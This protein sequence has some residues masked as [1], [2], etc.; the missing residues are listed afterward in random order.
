MPNA[1]VPARRETEIPPAGT[2]GVSGLMTLAVA[3][4]V[5]GGLYLGREVFVPMVLAVLLAF[6]IAPL[7]DLLRRWRLGRVP[8]VIVA[9]LVAL[10]IILSLG[11]VIGFQVADL[12]Q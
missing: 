1:P 4:V 9:V 2:P 12:A 8:A 6:V 11:T 3:V 5:L 10:G 7:V